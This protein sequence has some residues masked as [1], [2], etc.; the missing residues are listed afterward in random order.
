MG[1]ITLSEK[2]QRRSAVLARL[3]SGKLSTEEAA[4]LLRCSE[5]HVWRLSERFGDEGAACLVHANTGS[6]PVNKTADDVRERVLSLAGPGGK[7]HDFNTRHLAILLHREEQITIGRSTLDRLL[8][9]MGVR[10][11]SRSR[12]RRV[13][14]RRERSRQAGFMLLIDGSLHD[15]LEGRG[16]KMCLIGAIDDAT[17]EVVYLRFWPTECLS[18]YLLMLRSVAL[19]FGL[20][21]ALYHDKHTILRSP[22]E[23]SI[24]EQLSGKEPASQFQEVLSLLGIEGIPAHSPQAKGRIE[25]LWG[26]LQDRL[27]K[28]L[29]LAEARTMEDANAFLPTFIPRFNEEFGVK[30]A[31]AESAWVPVEA[32]MDLGYYFAKREGRTVRSDHTLSFS[33]T[34]LQV[35]RAKGEPSLA[36]KQIRVHTTPEGEILLYHGKT[37]LLYKPAPPA[38]ERT[39]V[40]AATQQPAHPPAQPTV[41]AKST[42]SAGRRAWLFTS[43]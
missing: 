30:A 5:R 39:K 19:T 17:G 40:Q 10:Q 23:A 2:Q 29:R 32:D 14:R 16:P 15:W 6:A 33:G 26:T 9:Q 41:R 1:T 13:F 7:Y 3:A 12:P 42:S 18:G 38:P 27:V 21:E 28:E 31:D 24:E 22:K 36:H 4:L 35:Q 8:K 34:E 20:P 11:R 25:R 43:P 37:R